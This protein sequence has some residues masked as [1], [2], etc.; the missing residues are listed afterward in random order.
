MT[1]ARLAALAIGLVVLGSS[2][3]PASA[4]IAFRA[5]ASDDLNGTNPGVIINVPT[6]TVQN[7]VMVASI[8]VRPNTVTITAPAGWTLV[9]RVNQTTGNAQSLAVYYRVAGA[10]E[11]ANYTWCLSASAPPACGATTSAGSAG[12]IISFSGV[13]SSSPVVVE[14]G[15]AIAA[16]TSF[17]APSVNTGA[18][19]NTML[20]TSFSFSSAE[21]FVAPV[22]MSSA[23]DVSNVAVTNQVGIDV[24]ATYAI[25]AAAGATGTRTATNGAVTGAEV[26]TTHMLALRPLVCAAVGDAVYLSAQAQSTQSTVYWSSP[27]NTNVIVLEKTSAFAGET[28]VNGTVYAAGTAVGAATVR[29]VGTASSF[30]RTGLTNNTTYYYKVFPYTSSQT[31]YASGTATVT[32]RPSSNANE[33]WSYMLAGGSALKPPLAGDDGVFFSSNSG[34]IMSL[35]SATGLHNWAP[36]ATTSAV[37]GWVVPA[38]LSAGG[39]RVF[40]GDQG[41]KAYAIDSGAGGTPVWQPATGATAIQAGPSVQLRVFSNAAFNT[42]FPGTYDLI[43]VATT[44]GAGTTNNKVYALRSD[45]GAI[46]WTFNG[47]GAGNNWSV[48]EINGMPAVD[49]TRN[50]LYVASLST[51]G[52]GASLWIVDITTG[53]L[54][55]NPAACP[56]ANSACVN[57]GNIDTSP[58]ISYDTN[59]LWVGNKTGSVYAIN[60]PSAPGASMMK[61]TAPLN[62]GANNQ[63]KGLVWEDFNTFNRL[64][65]VVANTTTANNAIRCFPDPGV[66]GTPNA[67][68]TCTVGG[69]WSTSTK[70]IN[71]AQAALPLDQLYVT[72]WDGTTG[73]IQQLD[74]ATGTLGTPFTI[75]DGTKQP[76]DVSTDLGA[77]LYVGTTEGKVFKISLPIPP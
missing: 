51:S 41:G 44:N 25:Q 31:C 55:G 22:G 27:T 75:G 11:P 34:Q 21:H 73:R 48:G 60:L 16:S 45:T 19:T 49:Y 26:G 14:N 59:T 6:G 20:V 40:A 32:A 68:T 42:Q 63:L 13:D 28:P 8:T 58:N 29:Y 43:Y 2:V 46:V 30:T 54:V 47:G 3:A 65:M 74:F 37:Q 1:T 61:W 15:S 33:Q 50:R 72:S 76:G 57:L 69:T 4:A 62:L 70:T 9:R 64:Y 12:G 10:A 66:G 5:A 38:N 67:A 53:R 18:V 24:L 71:G 23:Y 39:R 7:D 17:A 36:V 77:E 35:A 52:T 56:T